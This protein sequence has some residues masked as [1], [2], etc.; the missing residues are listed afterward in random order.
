[1]K[2]YREL[3]EALVG[4]AKLNRPKPHEELTE[5]QIKIQHGISDTMD[6]AAAAIDDLMNQLERVNEEAKRDCPEYA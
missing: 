5:M 2:E 1:M 3:I 4:L 6:D